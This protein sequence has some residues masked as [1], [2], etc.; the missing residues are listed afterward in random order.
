MKA[1]LDFATGV[2]AI[3]LGAGFFIGIWVAT[4]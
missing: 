2:L 1:L 3:A 4:P